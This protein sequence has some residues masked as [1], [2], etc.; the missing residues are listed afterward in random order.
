LGILQ[1]TRKLIKVSI[2]GY[3]KNQ[4]PTQHCLR[5]RSAPWIKPRVMQRTHY[6][7]YYYTLQLYFLNSCISFDLVGCFR[8]NFKVELVCAST[9]TAAESVVSM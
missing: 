7:Y 3:Y 9:Q 2:H 8:T 5:T 6:Y 4:I 1:G